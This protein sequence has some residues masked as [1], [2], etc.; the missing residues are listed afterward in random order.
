MTAGIRTQEDK[1]VKAMVIANVDSGKLS[2]VATA[3]LQFDEVRK[4][5]VT[6]GKSNLT[7]EITA[8][9]VKSFHE[10]LAAKLSNIEGL[11]IASSNMITQIIESKDKT[12]NR[13][14]P[15]RA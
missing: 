4:I 7:I 5:Y 10:L 2:S 9:N 8:K 13:L 14:D 15:R 3:L 12:M 6:T 11:S 1:G